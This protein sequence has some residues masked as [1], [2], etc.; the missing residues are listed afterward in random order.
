[1]PA[2]K[3]GRP[4]A[5]TTSSLK[6]ASRPR[7]PAAKKS[8]RTP[9]KAGHLVGVFGPFGSRALVELPTTVARQM[10]DDGIVDPAPAFLLDAVRAELASIAKRDKELAASARAELARSLAYEIANPHNSATSKA[11]CSRELR[12]TL[13]RL[14]EL[15]PPARQADRLD[16]VKQEREKRRGQRGRRRTADA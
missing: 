2:A 3:G 8:T 15:A 16:K 1:M 9:S 10:I 5:K 12:E 13:D 14:H 6:R 7:K 4:A 11:A